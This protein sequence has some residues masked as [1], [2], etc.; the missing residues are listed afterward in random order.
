MVDAG[1]GCGKDGCHGME[2]GGEGIVVNRG[3]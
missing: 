2:L 3:V 1:I